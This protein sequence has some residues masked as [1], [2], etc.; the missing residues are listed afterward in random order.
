MG[1]GET[2]VVG[3]WDN[4]LVVTEIFHRR[5]EGATLFLIRTEVG[6]YVTRVAS[7]TS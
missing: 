3:V 6:D 5:I 4:V 7:L 1:I 2:D